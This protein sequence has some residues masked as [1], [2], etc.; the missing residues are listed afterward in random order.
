MKPSPQAGNSKDRY[1]LWKTLLQ[2]KPAAHVLE[3]GVFEGEFSEFL[4]TSFPT[5]EAY[6]MI[7]P[8]AHL[9]EWNK[10]LNKSDDFLQHAHDKAMNRTSFAAEKIAVHRGKTTEMIHEIEDGTLD[11]VYIDGDHTLR[12]ILIDLIQ[13]LPKMKP[14]GWIAGDDFASSIWQHQAKFEPTLI[15]PAAVYVAEAWNKCIRSLP[16]S[17]FLIDL[18]S[19]SFQF[20][21]SLQKMPSLQLQEQMAKPFNLKQELKKWMS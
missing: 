1:D 8:W 6:H 15:F 18:S 13:V 12:G 9:D 19:E 7:D 21:Q 10:P 5:I 4:L 17:Q 16:H 14:N 2:T 11:F 20:D 3:I